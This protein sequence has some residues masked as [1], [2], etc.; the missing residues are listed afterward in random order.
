MNFVRFERKL[1]VFTKRCKIR[2]LKKVR[3]ENSG[4]NAKMCKLREKKQ[5]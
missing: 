5:L 4:I 2:K 1:F 3:V